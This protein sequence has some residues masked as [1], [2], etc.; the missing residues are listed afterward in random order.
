M[1]ERARQRYL[2]RHSEP[3]LPPGPQPATPWHN[4]LVIPAYREDPQLARR[5]RDLPAGQ[6][7]VTADSGI[8]DQTAAWFNLAPVI[9]A[10]HVPEAVPIPMAALC[11]PAS[12]QPGN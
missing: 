9:V 7:A 10:R 11:P 8:L 6:I 1:A 4:V 3:G 12:Q 2:Q 5:L